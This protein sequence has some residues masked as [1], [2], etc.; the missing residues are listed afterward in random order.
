MYGAFNNHHEKFILK[1][2]TGDSIEPHSEFD[3]YFKAN[4]DQDIKNYHL[5]DFAPFFGGL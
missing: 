5:C 1:Q 4:C 2:R 3:K